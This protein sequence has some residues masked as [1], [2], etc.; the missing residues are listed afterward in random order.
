MSAAAA[1]GAASTVDLLVRK[2]LVDDRLHLHAPLLLTFA[3]NLLDG[4]RTGEHSRGACKPS[5][6]AGC[7]R[8]HGRTACR[9]RP[10]NG[11]E[12]TVLQGRLDRTPRG[13]TL[14][15]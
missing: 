13:P 6:T 15:R 5:R 9:A 1:S 7:A 3:A 14:F 12:H 2:E 8:S 11:K 4:L 10:A